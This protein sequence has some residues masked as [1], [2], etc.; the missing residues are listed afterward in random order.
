EK[1]KEAPQDVSLKVELGKK[2]KEVLGRREKKLLPEILVL[3][4]HAIGFKENRLTNHDMILN[5]SLLLENKQQKRFKDVLTSLEKRFEGKLLFQAVL[6]LPPYSFVNISVKRSSFDELDKARR[7]LG[8]DVNITPA[9]LQ[10]AYEKMARLY[11]PDRNMGSLE[12]F[13]EIKKAYN[14]LRDFTNFYSCPLSRE[15]VEDKLIFSV[16]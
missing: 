14:A 11:H 8:L 5:L 2:V 9:E 15:E 7:T 10:A 4:E 12:K 16:N 6:P 3:K 1:V 13:N